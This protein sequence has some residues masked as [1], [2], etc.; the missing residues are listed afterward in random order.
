MSGKG[1]GEEGD[2]HLEARTDVG[3][4]VKTRLEGWR[5]RWGPCQPRKDETSQVERSRVDSPV[6]RVLEPG[7]LDSTDEVE[8]RG[9]PISSCARCL[10]RRA[11]D[12]EWGIR[13]SSPVCPTVKMPARCDD[14]AGS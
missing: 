10:E 6:I 1:S 2:G 13:W 12:L 5:W 9:N 7:N 11:G 14:R 3:K 4:G 8:L